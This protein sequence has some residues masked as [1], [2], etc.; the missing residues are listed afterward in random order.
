MTPTPLIIAADD[1]LRCELER[2]AAACGTA[3]RTAAE[4]AT[5]EGS[6][7]TAPRVLLDEPAARA[8]LESGLPCRREVYLLVRAPAEGTWQAAFALGAQDVVDLASEEH[9]VV[10]LLTAPPEADGSAGP[11]AVG[12]VLAVLGGSGGAGASLLAAE[13]AATA[14]RRGGRVLLLDG[15]PVGGGLDVV[16]GWEDVPGLRWGDVS[17][18]SGR[19]TAGTLHEALPAQQLGAGTL[20]VLACDRENP[21]SGFTAAAARSVLGAARQA[22][23]TVVCDV[24]RHL[25]DAAEAVLR[26]ADLVCLVARAELRA[27]A[28]AA[29]VL[30]RVRGAASAP[31]CLLV[32]SGPAAGMRAGDV[33]QVVGVEPLAVIR[34]Q[35]ELAAAADRRGI[36]TSSASTRGP[37]P[38]SAAAVLDL[39]DAEVDG[40]TA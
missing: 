22:G 16:L 33:R 10:D 19:V 20:A 37:L 28:A 14:A 30:G 29:A 18:G 3:A 27:C 26:H 25:A 1:E 12:R 5:V 17:I 39:L 13:T 9:R 21:D 15:D 35:P 23:D 8:A 34:D 11:A 40:Q 38:R 24:S 6:W 4:P 7:A 36:G 31:A 2:I 32:R